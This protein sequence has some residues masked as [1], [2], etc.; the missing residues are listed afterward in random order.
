[1][2]LRESKISVLS[3][4]II[5]TITI[6]FMIVELN[7]K[8]RVKTDYFEEK[9]HAAELTQKSFRVIKKAVDSL[10]IPIDRINDPN[11]TGLIGLQYS[12]ITTE[13]GDLDAKLTST[14][15]NFA[16][17]VVKFL[18]ETGVKN[19]DPVFVSLN[20]SFPA[21]NIAV[22]SAIRTLDLRPIIITSVGSSM[23]GANYPQ[24]TYLDMES[25]LNRAALFEFKTVAASIGG[26]DDIGR[27]LSPEG[28]EMIDASI[29]RSNIRS[30]GGNNI[31]EVIEK[32]IEIFNE[33][34]TA[35]L[36][37]NVG[38]QNTALAGAEI[39]SGF[40]K[41]RQIK[42]GTGL[43]AHFS[44]SGIPVINMIDINRLAQKYGLPLAPIPV[45]KVGTGSL[46]YEFK[47]SVSLAIILLIVLFIILFIVLRYD[48][49]YYL[50]R[51]KE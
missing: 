12:H 18:K 19:D 2:K 37:I 8:T 45:P 26:E 44:K 7:S 30:L 49:D 10:N 31:A 41:P 43:I 14:N 13:R 51:R 27:G 3:L 22:L 23:W 48:I 20:G 5:T 46:Y 4:S 6:I 16:A 38:E 33:Y 29:A 21:L 34:G 25:V 9:L 32:K 35:K 36:F 1:M 47:Y 50:K 24:F 17:L 42:L 11:E 39:S 15:P 40:I 28:R